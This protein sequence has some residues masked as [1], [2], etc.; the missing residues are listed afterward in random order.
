MSSA[1][2][3]VVD[4]RELV[5]LAA[6][7]KVTTHVGR[8]AKLSEINQI[9]DELEQGKFAGRAIINNLAD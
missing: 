8:V 4:M 9:I 6:E 7:G 5:Q 3:T 2:G 1:V